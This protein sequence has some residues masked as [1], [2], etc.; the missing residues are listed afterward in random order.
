MNLSDIALVKLNEAFASQALAVIRKL[1]ID[2]SI[3]NINGRA[4]ALASSIR[5]YRM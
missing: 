4:I 3:V 5:M 2:P 1:G